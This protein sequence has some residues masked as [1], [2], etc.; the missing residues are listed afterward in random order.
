MQNFIKEQP[1]INICGQEG[2]N[3]VWKEGKSQA[4]GLAHLLGFKS[5]L[6]SETLKI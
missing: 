4:V 5:H 3:S 6:D 1:G 2:K